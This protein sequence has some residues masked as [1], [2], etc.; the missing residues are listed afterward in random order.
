MNP[1][2]DQLYLDQQQAVD[3]EQR[4]AIIWEMQKLAFEDRPYIVLYYQDL[5]RAYRSDRFTG[6]IESPIGIES[7]QS[8]MQVKPV[9]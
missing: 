8:L 9:Q 3:P 4:K 1:E 5:L 7:F 6:F 2:Y